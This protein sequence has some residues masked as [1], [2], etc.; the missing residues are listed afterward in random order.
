MKN[1]KAFILGMAEFKSTY[2]THHAD[3]RE[4]DCY[5]RG[6]ELAHKL[7]FRHFEQ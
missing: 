2:T 4:A 1:I 7:T 3:L 5:D 6:R